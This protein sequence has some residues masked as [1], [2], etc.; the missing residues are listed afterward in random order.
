MSPWLL[1]LWAVVGGN[2]RAFSV[3]AVQMRV[4]KM[5]LMELDATSRIENH[6]LL[7]RKE[8][9]EKAYGTRVGQGK[10]GRGVAGTE[11]FEIA[12]FGCGLYSAGTEPAGYP[13]APD[14]QRRFSGSQRR[15]F[16]SEAGP[17]EE[18]S[19]PPADQRFWQYNPT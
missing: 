1:R 3:N 2:G 16:G 5:I 7:I 18:A 13:Q 4:R 8:R 15:V 6:A 9:L 12:A 10:A 17:S 11:G 19:V 14:F